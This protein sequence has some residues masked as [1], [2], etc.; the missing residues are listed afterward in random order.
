MC[1]N[2]WDDYS[3]RIRCQ[4]CRML[5]LI[6]PT[7]SQST[8]NIICEICQEKQLNAR[9]RVKNK[10]KILCL[11]GFRQTSKSFFGR[12]CAL[13]KKLSEIAEFEFIDGP[14]ELPFII[15]NNNL[16]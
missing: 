5:V 11:H 1:H 10:L 3:T 12:T 2:S 8:Q 7:C 13:R 6:C 14:H 15:S 9:I 4:K 16:K